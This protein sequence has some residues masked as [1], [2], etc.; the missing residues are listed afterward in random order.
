[1][2]QEI[3]YDHKLFFP[4]GP[5]KFSNEEIEDDLEVVVSHFIKDEDFIK[6]LNDGGIPFDKYAVKMAFIWAFYKIDNLKI[7]AFLQK[8]FNSSPDHAA[9]LEYVVDIL[10]VEKYGLSKSNPNSSLIDNYFPNNAEK[11]IKLEKAISW[12]G[13]KN[14]ELSEN[15]KPSNFTSLALK[16]ND[17]KSS[18]DIIRMIYSLYK[19][20][21]FP[22]T[23]LDT[24]MEQFGK[25]LTID[26]R[27]HSAILSQALNVISKE[28]NV[29]IFDKMKKVIIDRIDKKLDL[30]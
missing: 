28:A 14:Q 17:E 11:F 22:N 15:A 21:Y 6:P 16:I 1:M 25:F 29:E 26:L 19:L 13:K 8:L 7:G 18:T 20:N 23:T 27:N 5:F 12:I 3:K 24:V 30:P 9:F 4:F 10:N 2:S